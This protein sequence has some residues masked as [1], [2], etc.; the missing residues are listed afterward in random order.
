M[1]IPIFRLFL[2]VAFLERASEATEQG[3]NPLFVILATFMNLD[4]ALGKG[5]TISDNI[6]IS[7]GVYR[8]RL[9]KNAFL[10][11]PES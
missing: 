4:E 5:S 11:T 7:S 9:R 1:L 6:P 10:P 3:W 8:N 2:T